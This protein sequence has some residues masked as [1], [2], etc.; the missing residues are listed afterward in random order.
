MLIS[1]KCISS[2]QKIQEKPHPFF[3]GNILKDFTIDQMKKTESNGYVYD[4]SVDF[5]ITDTHDILDI[6]KHLMKKTRNDIR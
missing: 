1:Q 6:H 2:K 5:I 4:F 3:L